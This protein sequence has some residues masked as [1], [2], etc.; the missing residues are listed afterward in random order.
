MIVKKVERSEKSLVKSKSL[1]INDLL[2]YIREPT[3]VNPEEKVIFSGSRGFLS[4]QHASQKSE[5]IAL[6][7]SKPRSKMPV[8]HW[9]FS[10]RE[11]EQPT[12]QQVEELVDVFL[13][14]MGLEDHQLIYGVHVDT[15]N[16]HL[17]IA[18]NRINP[19]TLD[20][21]KPHKGFDKEAAHKI[22]A[23]IEAMQGWQKEKNSR[24]DFVD[25]QAVRIGVNS[26]IST[27]QKATSFE[28]ATGA[29]SAERI[30][31][32]RGL[33]L[34][35]N[36]GSWQELHVGLAA[37]GM[38]YMSKGTGATLIVVGVHIKASAVGR[39]CSMKALTRRLGP[40]KTLEQ[41]DESGRRY[42][43]HRPAELGP[44]ATPRR[45]LSEHRLRVLSQCHLAKS[46]IGQEQHHKGVLQIDA[47]PG[48][49]GAGSL[50]RDSDISRFEP[51][52]GVVN[53]EKWEEYIS[54][55]DSYNRGKKDYKSSWEKL[56]SVHDEERKNLSKKLSDERKEKLKGEWK[57]KG[58]ALNALRSVLA[59]EQ[60]I[61][62]ATQ[63]DQ[64]KKERERFHK[65]WR[66]EQPVFP[67]YEDW[68]RLQGLEKDAELWRYRNLCA[69]SPEPSAADPEQRP[70]PEGIA[71]FESKIGLHGYV[72]YHLSGLGQSESSAFTDIGRRLV[73]H[74]ETDKDAVLAAL[75]LASQKW[76][77]IELQ[78][79]DT[80]KQL[81][82][83]LAAEHGF[84]ITNAE[85]QLAMQEARV[86]LQAS[87]RQPVLEEKNLFQTYHDAVDAASYR[88][89]CIRMLENGEKKT[90]IL[91]KQR[92]KQRGFPAEELPKFLPEML[93]IQRRGENI[94]YTPLSDDKHHILIDDMD[95]NKLEKLIE[96]GYAPAVLLESSPGNYQAIIT[97]PKLGTPHDKDVGNRITEQLNREYGDQN[98]SGA[99]HPHRAPGFLNQK[100]KHKRED[101]SFPQVKLLKSERRQCVKAL[102]LS[103]QINASYVEQAKDRAL[104]SYSAPSVAPAGS[105][106][107]AYY[108]HLEN[109]R[110]H[111][112]IT[113]PSRVDAM[114]A[115]RLRATGHSTE[116]VQAAISDCASTWRE[117]AESRDWEQYAQR[118][119]T[120]AFGVAGDRDLQR[121]N[122]YVDS[123]LRIEG[124]EAQKQKHGQ[125]VNRVKQGKP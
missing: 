42:F 36:A 39:D 99:I 20:V 21:I 91:D 19:D 47:R 23:K 85:L 52:N 77:A 15:D 62:R 73:I 122:G 104:F 115:V 114:I 70:K 31:Q 96:D 61:A 105:A 83:E 18:V 32:E 92:G 65:N 29:K 35:R 94:Y 108:K 55:R 102:E 6:A 34:I 41:S 88:V 38:E 86:Q 116:A 57:G 58:P 112:S 16:Y 59:A 14:D 10:W 30:A 79:T 8:Q 111:L 75:Q 76:G 9:I 101:G 11:G 51:V 63:K 93:K 25:N 44:F 54:A 66:N 22:V 89:T 12:H 74:A 124:R 40:F 27:G 118:T 56:K 97:I 4:E 110:Q 121:Y 120:Y 64:H 48:R 119:T 45:K 5:M 43:V 33:H 95:R 78:G 49:R 67:K 17:H 84:R 68:L 46:K 100:A 87:R 82:V 7:H 80:Y 28:V 71:N 24:Y 117:K 60:A 13:K 109:I 37:V 113:D 81:C 2:D 1:N 106:T 3:R 90:F 72:S 125:R 50:R 26:G 98:F 53:K 69:I 103:K 123:W 107:D